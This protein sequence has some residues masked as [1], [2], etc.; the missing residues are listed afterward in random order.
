MFGAE[1]GRGDHLRRAEGRHLVAQQNRFFR[2]CQRDQFG[3]GLLGV[4]PVENLAVEAAV[5]FDADLVEPLAW[6]EPAV[7][8]VAG[9]M[10]TRRK[11]RDAD[12]AGTGVG[13]ERGSLHWIISCAAL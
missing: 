6:R 4:E 5:F 10:P 13:S 12:P 9:G 8:P 11:P 2:R 7:D 1:A 3:I